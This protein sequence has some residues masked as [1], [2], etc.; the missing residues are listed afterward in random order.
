M[1]KWSHLHWFYL[2]QREELI[3][4]HNIFFLNLNLIFHIGKSI[5]AL[6]LKIRKKK[7]WNQTNKQNTPGYQPW[8]MNQW[9]VSM[10]TSC[11]FLVQSSPFL[12]EVFRFHSIESIA[13]GEG[14]SLNYI[15]YHSFLFS[16]D[17]PLSL[18]GALIFFLGFL[19]KFYSA[20]TF[21]WLKEAIFTLLVKPC[22]CDTCC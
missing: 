11:F 3:N 13:C 15:T 1:Q 14:R 7:Q 17:F 20:G 16:I 10:R 18:P 8:T 9:P 12:P 22:R 5:S 19:R 4:W 2:Q 6:L 21:I